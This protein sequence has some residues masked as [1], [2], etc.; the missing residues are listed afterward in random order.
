MYVSEIQSLLEYPVNVKSFLF[1]DLSAEIYPPPL[2][3][4][5]YIVAVVLSPG[6]QNPVLQ[7][8]APRGRDQDVLLRDQDV[9]VVLV[10]FV[11]DGAQGGP[12]APSERGVMLY[13]VHYEF[14]QSKLL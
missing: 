1:H 6:G 12:M 8:H 2:W 11:Q 5:H 13:N 10:L 4:V 7:Q 14:M 3:E 9:L